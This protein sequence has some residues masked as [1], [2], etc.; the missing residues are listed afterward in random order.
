M[1]L[2]QLLS[3]IAFFFITGASSTIIAV[4]ITQAVMNEKLRNIKETL[5]NHISTS[6]DDT[7]K[8]RNEIS[9]SLVGCKLNAT[10]KMDVA[11]DYIKR[12]ELNKAD[13]S[14]V[15]LLIGSINRIEQ[16]VDLIIRD[17]NSK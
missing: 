2:S 8:I 7:E 6:I 12:V 11:M 16:K 1:D 9:N 15:N 17:M 13:R 5:D 3:S 14:E 4:K 10:E